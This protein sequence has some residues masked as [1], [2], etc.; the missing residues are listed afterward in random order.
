M[1]VKYNLELFKMKAKL[2]KTFSDP[3]RLMIIQ[4]LREGEKPVGN[5]QSVLG[6]PQA[7]VSRH[8]AIL[9]EKGV[10]STR[11]EGSNIY[12]RLTNPRVCEACDIIHQIL[13]QQIESGRELA[14]KLTGK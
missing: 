14:Q 5:L 8:L 12:Y 3:M 10:V 1:T 11:R 9:R 2:C 6:I 13:I 7:T 4:E